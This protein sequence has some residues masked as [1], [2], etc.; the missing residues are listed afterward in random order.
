M[1]QSLTEISKFLSYILRHKPDAIGLK[2]DAQGWAN[3]KDII[4]KADIEITET[5]I[6]NVVVS[7]D[8]K[9]FIIS[10]D[11]LCI[12]ANQGHSVDIDLGLKP[13]E[14][15]EILYHGTASRFLDE[16]RRHGLRPQN[17]QYVHL[18]DNVETAMKVG[19]RHGKSVVLSIPAQSMHKIGHLFF[20]A[21][22]GVWLIKAVPAQFISGL[23]V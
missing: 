20:Q 8:K 1:T 12:R 21:E 18:S 17:R 2:I 22:N 6:K 23:I 15:P 9:R 5:M 16:I 14:P 13:K 19:Q 7:S 10:D 4:E 3:I 11:G